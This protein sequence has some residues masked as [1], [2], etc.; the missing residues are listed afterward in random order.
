MLSLSRTGV[1]ART[2]FCD[3]TDPGVLKEEAIGVPSL[4]CDRK[5]VASI[6]FGV[7]TA[8]EDGTTLLKSE[9]MSGVFKPP[10]KIKLKHKL[11]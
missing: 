8:F 9:L 5:G 7:T 11:N 3:R 2:P 4:L 1:G 10:V 6:V